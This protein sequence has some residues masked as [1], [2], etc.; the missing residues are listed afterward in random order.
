MRCPG[1][2]LCQVS[3]AG[4]ATWMTGDSAA[5]AYALCRVPEEVPAEVNA[6]I[7]SCLSTDAGA[8]PCALDLV[9]F[10]STW[11]A[12]GTTPRLRS[13]AL[14]EVAARRSSSSGS[15][16]SSA[17]PSSSGG[18]PNST[19]PAIPPI[20]E[21]GASALPRR[22][23][24]EAPLAAMGRGPA[25][26]DQRAAPLGDASAVAV[27]REGGPLELAAAAARGQADG[28]RPVPT[29]GPMGRMDSSGTHVMLLRV[30]A[31][32]AGAPAAVLDE[33]RMAGGAEPGTVRECSTGD[34][35]RARSTGGAPP[36][37]AAAQQ[38]HVPSR[39]V[40]SPFAATGE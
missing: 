24:A 36:Q 38:G 19:A 4:A 20:L 22:R 7:D 6:V 30:P 3:C 40:A 11:G 9:G 28:E 15:N 12:E 33:A 14:L 10:F 18:A 39:P 1:R 32:A 5:A 21:N 23:S 27:R 16:P 29:A 26:G 17:A 8:R 37:A 34:G 31:D 35:S 13:S 2:Q 25:N